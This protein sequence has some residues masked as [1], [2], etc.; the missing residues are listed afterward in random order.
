MLDI[1]A[2]NRKKCKIMVDTAPPPRYK[3]HISTDDS[4]IKPRGD[5]MKLGSINCYYTAIAKSGSKVIMY[6]GTTLGLVKSALVAKVKVGSKIK[7]ESKTYNL[8]FAPHDDRLGYWV[9]VA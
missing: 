5:F 7:T 4:A 1:H 8:V 3:G 6:D 2:H 9:E